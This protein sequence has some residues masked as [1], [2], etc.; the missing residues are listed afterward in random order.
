[1]ERTSS[2]GLLKA[3]GAG[4]PLLGKIF[5]KLLLNIGLRGIIFGNLCA[6]LICA[7]QYYFKII[8]LDPQNYYMEYVPIK[9]SFIH[10]GIINLGMMMLLVVVVVV[11]LIVIN[12]ISPAKAVKFE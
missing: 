2:I 10:C 9:W 5:L 6:I 8:P 12:N 3:L 4:E 1:M 7:L 11:P